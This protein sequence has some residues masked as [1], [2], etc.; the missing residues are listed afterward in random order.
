LLSFLPAKQAWGK[1]ANVRQVPYRNCP[2]SAGMQF[3]STEGATPLKKEESLRLITERKGIAF[4]V[5]FLFAAKN[6]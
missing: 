2:A 1:K 5:L 4:S 6:L 3:F